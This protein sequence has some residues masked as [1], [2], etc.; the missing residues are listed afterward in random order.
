MIR[1][2]GIKDTD[3][4][5]CRISVFFILIIILNVKEILKGHCQA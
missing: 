5:H 2:I 1:P 3:F 4:R